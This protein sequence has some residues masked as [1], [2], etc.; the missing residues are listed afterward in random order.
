MGM[1]AARRQLC[2]FDRVLPAAVAIAEMLQNASQQD[3]LNSTA[4]LCGI[5]GSLFLA[6]SPLLCAVMWA[7]QSC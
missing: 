1:L 4:T 7:K 2:S 5:K 3:G 6:Q